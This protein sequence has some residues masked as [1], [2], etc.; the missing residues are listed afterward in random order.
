MFI[1]RYSLTFFIALCFFV[2]T[3]TAKIIN[4]QP[5]LPSIECEISYTDAL[6][7]GLVEGITEYLPVS[8]TGHLI[9]TNHLLGLDADTPLYDKTGTAVV[10]TSDAGA[11]KQFTL[12]N[13][14]DAYIII[15]QIG[16]IIAVAILYWKRILTIFMGL[17]GKNPNGLKLLLNLCFAFIPAAV[18]GL[19]LDEIIASLLFG[20]A[21]VCT[22]LVA[23]AVLMLAVTHWHKSKKSNKN[24]GVM[25]TSSPDLH[26]LSIA[27][28]LFIG[29]LQCVAMWPGTS[30]SMMTIVGGYIVGL[31]P[32]RAAEFSFLL[33]LITLTA[34][35]AYKMVQVGP[36]I[37]KAVPIG[38]VLLGI[39]VATI[40]AAI[41]VRWLVSFLTKHGLSLFA[42]YRIGLALIVI[43][44]LM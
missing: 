32:V 8:S 35:S 13:A 6:I 42:W 31:S 34:A 3:L 43:L 9:I 23:G 27:H 22:A 10:E 41:A 30:R 15:I 16:A 5:E 38:P 19:L 4:T 14:A 11:V 33:G 18:L 17:L 24:T 2:T 36:L 39:F 40:S 44:T 20:I 37:A 1:H 28:S 26:E 25:E 12:A 29:L 21:P 7:L